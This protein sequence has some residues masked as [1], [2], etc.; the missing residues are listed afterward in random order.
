VSVV[1]GDLRDFEGKVAFSWRFPSIGAMAE[2]VEA[3]FGAGTS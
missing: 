1:G 2:T 3:A